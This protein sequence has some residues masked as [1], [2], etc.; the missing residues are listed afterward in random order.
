LDAIA[1]ASKHIKVCHAGLGSGIQSFQWIP[2]FA[3]IVRNYAIAVF[4]EGII[5]DTDLASL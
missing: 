1:L 4:N 3:G 5:A 2:A